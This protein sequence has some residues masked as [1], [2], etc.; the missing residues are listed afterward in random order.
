MRHLRN[1]TGRPARSSA[2]YGGQVFDSV[3]ERVHF[4]LALVAIVVAL[5]VP[6]AAQ[7]RAAGVQMAFARAQ[8]LKHGINASVG[9][10][11]RAITP[12]RTRIATRTRRT[13][14]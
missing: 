2:W 10:H 6:A 12:P 3:G 11:S 13:L 1:A 14:R 4:R 7:D 9:S 8:H 5:A